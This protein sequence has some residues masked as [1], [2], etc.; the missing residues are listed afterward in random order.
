M[1][2]LNVKLG[3]DAS[4]FTKGLNDAFKVAGQS[5]VAEVDKGLDKALLKA[6]KAKS[7]QE[8]AQ[9]V[10][11]AGLSFDQ[12]AGGFRDVKTGRFVGSAA[13]AGRVERAGQGP[14]G[15]LQAAA[16]G[17]AGLA[18]GALIGS[19]PALQS[20]LNR[21]LAMLGRLLQPLGN[22]LA[23]GL[24]PLVELL[25]PFIP[26]AVALFRPLTIFIRG[27]MKGVVA[28]NKDI[29]GGLGQLFGM[30]NLDKDLVA[31]SI[32]VLIEA[33]AAYFL[34]TSA[35]S[36]A[37]ALIAPAVSGLFTAVSGVFSAGAITSAISGALVTVGG[38]IATLFAG[39]SSSL[40]ASGLSL[41]ALGAIGLVAAAALLVG[42][43]IYFLLDEL[44]KGIKAMNERVDAELKAIYSTYF[45]KYS[46]ATTNQARAAAGLKPLES[47][48][49]EDIG[50][51]GKPLTMQPGFGGQY[52][53]ISGPGQYGILPVQPYRPAP[54]NPGYVNLNP[55]QTNTININVE[56]GMDERKLAATIRNE[57]N[58]SLYNATRQM[59]T[60]L[61]P[62]VSRG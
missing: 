50:Y 35:I 28:L 57:V 25:R 22:L 23:E 54:M 34:V 48:T 26:I 49:R 52:S 32:L 43:A 58:T 7:L 38:A 18:A 46:G 20:V 19:S 24:Q 30:P 1:A 33:V 47:P 44:G 60:S 36:A 15:G 8:E 17:P 13:A 45:G 62:L 56:G 16:L 12:A 9:K 14:L 59:N 27:L 41:G 4:K 55:S 42:A 10:A 5:A 3:F 31:N 61:G 11:K 21:L 29:L 6:R 37:G 51:T 53:P 39:I 2:G 40:A